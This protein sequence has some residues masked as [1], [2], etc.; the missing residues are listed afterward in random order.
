MDRFF[1]GVLLVASLHLAAFSSAETR[2]HVVLYLSDDHAY[3]DSGLYGANDIPTP[4]M[5]ALA[6]DGVHLTHAFVASPSCAPSRAALLTG[7]MPARNGAEANHTQP[8]PAVGHLISSIV[9]EGYEIA[10]IGKVSHGVRARYQGSE[11]AYLA[12]PGLNCFVAVN[13]D[14]PEIHVS[15]RSEDGFDRTLVSGLD[16]KVHLA[17]AG[18]DLPL[19]EIYQGVA[20]QRAGGRN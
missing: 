10:H 9:E 12:I 4:N 14:T 19:A 13:Q 17:G 18:I 16:E 20:A 2:P 15:W 8:R 7:L 1:R 5:V 6:A 11:P 3:Y